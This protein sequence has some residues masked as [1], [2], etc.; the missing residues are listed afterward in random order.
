MDTVPHIPAAG[1]SVPHDANSTAHCIQPNLDPATSSLTSTTPFYV[2]STDTLQPSVSPSSALYKYRKDYQTQPSL[3]F[4]HPGLIPPPELAS[5]LS[6]GIPTKPSITAADVLAPSPSTSFT[7]SALQSHL[8]AQ[9]ESSYRSHRLQP[10]G[11]TP[12]R[13]HR[14]PAETSEADF[15][16]GLVNHKGEDAKGLI[17]APTQAPRGEATDGGYYDRD[18]KGS[19]KAVSR[20]EEEE[21]TR[22]AHRAYEWAA[23]GIDPASFRFGH[24]KGAID[25]T[26]GQVKAALAFEYDEKETQL[27]DSRVVHYTR[28]TKHPVGATKDI[29]NPL[30]SHLHSDPTFRFGVPSPHDAVDA[31]AVVRGQYSEA[32]QQPDADLGRA[33]TRTNRGEGGQA[34]EEGRVYGLPSIRN[35]RA[36]P[37]MK[38]VANRCNYGDEGSSKALL[39]PAPYAHMGL[40]DEQLWQEREEGELRAL[41]ERVGV[42]V[43]DRQWRLLCA[44]AVKLYGALSVDSLRHAMNRQAL[45]LC[46]DVC[47][48]VQCQHADCAERHCAH[49]GMEGM[50]NHRA[51]MQH[52]RVAI[53][54]RRP[55]GAQGTGYTPTFK[56][57]T[58]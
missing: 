39:Y 6:H 37:R 43:K 16:F 45:Q 46:C 2:H 9:R 58:G 21:V 22:P 38:S 10:L 40:H 3:R 32:E 48:A 54:L 33:V 1:F 26:G 53:T 29:A 5:S 55:A 15:R 51:F 17:Y 44:M 23:K 25:P 8:Q 4:S 35:D 56:A 12:S 30:V 11:R 41:Y 50:G 36:V 19:L 52:E 57:G 34:E 7:P 27:V 13:G 20:Q 47:G 14:L 28:A 31:K 49:D 24:S 18:R 42:R